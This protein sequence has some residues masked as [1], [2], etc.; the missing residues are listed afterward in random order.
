METNSS[1]WAERDR[2]RS[3]GHLRSWQLTA[4]CANTPC[5]LAWTVLNRY[6][7]HLLGVGLQYLGSG[8]LLACVFRTAQINNSSTVY[9]HLVAACLTPAATPTAVKWKKKPILA[10]QGKVVFLSGFSAFLCLTTAHF[11]CSVLSFLCH[12]AQA[13]S[14]MDFNSDGEVS[15]DEFVRW[16]SMSSALDEPPQ[17]RS[18]SGTANVEAVATPPAP[19]A[20]LAPT[21]GFEPGVSLAPAAANTRGSRLLTDIEK[22]LALT[23]GPPTVIP[24]Q[25]S[26]TWL[27]AAAAAV[28]G[29]GVVS[30]EEEK[31]AARER[32][33]AGDAPDAGSEASGTKAPDGG[34]SAAKDLDKA[35]E[36][37][38]VLVKAH[39]DADTLVAALASQI[40]RNPSDG[41]FNL[42]VIEE[43][44]GPIIRGIVEDRLLLERLPEPTSSASYLAIQQVTNRCMGA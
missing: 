16:Y 39:A 33:L 32:W 31:E 20:A 26:S 30:T 43:Q 11:R 19:E 7:L 37:L 27:A 21:G 2:R 42:E 17:P 5:K 10:A 44:F 24:P 38:C 36:M 40:I 22:S 4:R 8:K 14:E 12:V 25:Q 15:F 3:K 29:A 9:P 13:F 1:T 6:L 18:N 34:D 28:A 23:G 41:K 35:L